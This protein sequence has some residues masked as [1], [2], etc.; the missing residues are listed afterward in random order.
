MKTFILGSKPLIE[1]NMKCLEIAATNLMQVRNFSS[2]LSEI[3][4]L[5][6]EIKQIIGLIDHSK[7]II[8]QI[9]A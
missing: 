7:D 2:N 1:L 3:N 9:E 5:N 6:N 4:C 8:E